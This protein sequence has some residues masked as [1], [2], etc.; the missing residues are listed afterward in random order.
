MSKR[1]FSI[2][3]VIVAIISC[4]N[5]PSTD[6]DAK[7]GEI[8]NYKE[9]SKI[10]P[11]NIDSLYRIASL[12]PDDT[13]KVNNYITTYKLSIRNRPIRIDILDKALN[14]SKKLNYDTGIAI[15]LKNKGLD[16]RYKHEYIKSIKYHKEANKYFKNSWDTLSRIKNLNSLGVSFRRIN[17]EEEAI[18]YYF[19]ALDLSKEIESTKS[20]AIAMNGI[21]NAYVVLGKYDDAINL[22]KLALNLELLCN[23]VRG[24]GYDYSNLGEA[25]MYK[26]EYDSSFYYH[27]KALEVANK[28]NIER[29][30]AIIYSSIGQM[31][32]H[33]GN[34]D[35]ALNYYLDA[36]PTFK[37]YHNKRLLSFSMINVG[38]IY[39]EKGDIEKSENYINKGLDLSK[40]ISTKDNNVLAY[41]A[42][43]E[44][45]ETKGDYKKALDE[46]KNM[47]VYRDSIFNK[48]S[49]YNIEAMNIKYESEIKEDEIVR[50]HLESEVQK[51][52]IIIQ[53]L[54]IIILVALTLF[55][56]FYIRIRIK[57]KNQE[58]DEMRNK[59]EEY[60][61]HIAELETENNE[62]IIDKHKLIKEKYGLSAREEEVLSLIA[63]GLKNKEIADKMFVSLST[64]KTHTKN[65]FD[66]LDVRN[67]IEAAKK[68]KAI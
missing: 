68:I 60:L 38:K 63:Q 5:N 62:S 41:E 1:I 17:A 28:L 46:Y 26:E 43:S 34:L 30:K 55:F 44:L 16:H 40:K 59:I 3:I 61:Q 52:K 14:L 2:F 49:Y 45:Y 50:L 29:D 11:L 65:I 31:Y 32:Q 33:K 35:M 48:K 54:A 27:K 6:L 23:S 10:R 67:R 57:N 25:Y 4:N 9:L 19:Q 18:K 36:I 53:Y 22:F 21:G 47:T 42:L 64:V 66:K 24:T 37:K 8:F 56:V 7:S 20:M 39:L 13:V 51:S 58:I 12:Q 15:C